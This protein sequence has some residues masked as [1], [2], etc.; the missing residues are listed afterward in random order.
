MTTKVLQAQCQHLACAQIRA[1]SRKLVGLW[2]KG[3]NIWI[4]AIENH[5]PPD[6]QD[7]CR[8]KKD[9]FHVFL[10]IISLKHYSSHQP[11][12]TEIAEH[13]TWYGPVICPSIPLTP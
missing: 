6:S 8:P 5:V 13:V 2:D 4:D 10:A 1:V 3:S 9:A 12:E 7:L 11:I